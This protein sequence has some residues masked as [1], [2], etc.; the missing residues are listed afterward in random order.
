MSV[1]R[2]PGTALPAVVVKAVNSQ[3]GMVGSIHD[4][5]KA[6]EMGYRGGLVGGSM[7]MGYMSRLMGET[8]G[9]RW[10]TDGTMQA[11][12]RRPLYEGDDAR[13]EGTVTG[14]ADGR[15]EVELRVIDPE[16]KVCAVASASC[17]Q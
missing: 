8:F 12:L 9:E 13:V 10:A 4:D 11:H 14:V 7:V 16:G 15:V 6:Q 1:T 5:A 3:A 17:R 2:T